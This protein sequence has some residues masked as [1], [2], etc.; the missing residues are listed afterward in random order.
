MFTCKAGGVAHQHE[1]ASEGQ[2]CYAMYAAQPGLPPTWQ[3]SK[4]HATA[5]V[6][7]QPVRQGG[8]TV[9]TRATSAPAITV[10][11]PAG[12][13]ALDKGNGVVKFYRVDRPIEG[14]WKGY[15]FVKR[16]A[17]D[18]EFNVADRREREAILREIGKDIAGASKLYGTTL[19]V[20]G[21]CGRTLTDP[22][23]RANGIGPVCAAKF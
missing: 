5:A 15:T 10:D 16:Q 19:G 17:G 1:R 8:H 12:R 18:D 6:L 13:Y 7:G 20:C 21:V 11:V 9:A 22:D 2:S 23:S 3:A 14:R 4:A